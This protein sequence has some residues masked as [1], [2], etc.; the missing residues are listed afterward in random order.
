MVQG[1]IYDVAVDLR[2]DSPT[3]GQYFGIDLTA[4]NKSMLFIPEGFGHGF[5]CLE[6]QTI[7]QYKCSD[8][9]APDHEI[10]VK[11]NDATIGIDWPIK[12]P[13][14]SNKDTKH[15]ALADFTSPF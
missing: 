7:V 10:G 1:S 3:Y 6:N 4:E 8:Y 13:F 12:D 5:C 9:Y 2:K 14:L 11:W 15:P